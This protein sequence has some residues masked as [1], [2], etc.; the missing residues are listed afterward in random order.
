[1]G[2]KVPAA[3]KARRLIKPNQFIS[4][5]K[6]LLL[7][8]AMPIQPPPLVNHIC[9]FRYRQK[10]RVSSVLE[11]V[12]SIP[13]ATDSIIIFALHVFLTIWCLSSFLYGYYCHSPQSIIRRKKIC[14]KVK[15]CLSFFIYN[16]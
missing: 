4:Q 8:L 14:E 7:N 2:N 13:V 1:M 6:N 11:K 5:N 16:F 9:Q 15:R 10:F 3:N 12:V